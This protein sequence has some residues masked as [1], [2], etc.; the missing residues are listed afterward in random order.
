MDV[1]DA[2]GEQSQV[3]SPEIRPEEASPLPGASTEEGSGVQ[4]QKLEVEATTSEDTDQERGAAPAED[5]E[6]GFRNSNRGSPEA[7]SI[8][9]PEKPT[10]SDDETDDSAAQSRSGGVED[11]KDGNAG[12]NAHG[13]EGMAPERL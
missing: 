3:S 2:E 9:A 12:K 1:V 13:S 8:E 7:G 11:G 4:V 6:G 10:M 5:T